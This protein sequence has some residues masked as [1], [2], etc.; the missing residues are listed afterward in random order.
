M[1]GCWKRRWR[2]WRAGMSA[3]CSLRMAAEF[4]T[5]KRP[6]CPRGLGGGGDGE[7]GFGTGGVGAGNA[8]IDAAV[9]ETCGDLQVDLIQ[10]GEL[11]RQAIELNGGGQASNRRGNRIYG[12]AERIHR[13]WGGVGD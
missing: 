10:A 6:V 12:R 3:T 5:G 4:K 9:T 13:A 1:R 11:R 2:R 8:E 7:Q